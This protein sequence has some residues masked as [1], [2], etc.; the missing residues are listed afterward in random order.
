[1]TLQLDEEKEYVASWWNPDN[2]FNGRFQDEHGIGGGR[3]R[4]VAPGKND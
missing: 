2:G 3:Q 4:F 1:M